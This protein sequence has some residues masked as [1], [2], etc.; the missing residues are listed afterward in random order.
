MPKCLIPRDSLA[1]DGHPV[2]TLKAPNAEHIIL[3]AQRSVLVLSPSPFE[4]I[5][6]GWQVADHEVKVEPFDVS[7]PIPSSFTPSLI[8][9]LTPDFEHT[10]RVP[11]S[12]SPASPLADPP[13][14]INAPSTV[15][16]RK[17]SHARRRDPGPIPR[18][19]NAFIFFRSAYINNGS[20]TGEGQQNS[21]LPYSSI[22]FSL[23]SDELQYPTYPFSGN[24]GFPAALSHIEIPELGYTLKIKEEENIER[25]CERPS[26]FHPHLDRIPQQGNI[27]TSNIL[28]T[29]FPAIDLSAYLYPSAPSSLLCDNP[30]PSADFLGSSSDT[31]GGELEGDSMMQHYTN[32]LTKQAEV[33]SESP[34]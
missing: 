26:P 15:P 30:Y 5:E 3:E 11:K 27:R 9:P 33:P 19:R 12:E 2:R 14:D 29:S 24:G 28:T 1:F 32:N 16:S 23:I 8:S 13:F 22:Q 10:L 17:N 6:D 34:H 31:F 25:E 20:T 18:P 21:P 4:S 7:I